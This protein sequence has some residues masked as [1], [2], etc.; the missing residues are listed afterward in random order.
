MVLIHTVMEEIANTVNMEL[1]I[2]GVM[3]LRDNF[4]LLLFYILIKL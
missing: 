1:F 3:I 2:T 4:H